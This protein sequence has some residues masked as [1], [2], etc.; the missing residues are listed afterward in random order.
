MQMNKQMR[1]FDIHMK[2]LH[3]KLPTHDIVDAAKL[4]LNKIISDME[5]IEQ[6]FH[7][8]KHSKRN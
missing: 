2:D 5:I 7:K 4:W 6:I 8:F 3:V 1:I